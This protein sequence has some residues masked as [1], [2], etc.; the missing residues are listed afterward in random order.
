MKQWK[1]NNCDPG[2]VVVVPPGSFDLSLKKYVA[3]LTTGVPLRDGD[4]QTSND[5]SD[6]DRDILTVPQGG[7]MRYRFVVRNL[8]PVT[9]TGT[10]TV[11]DTLPNDTSIISVAGSGWSCTTSETRKFIC[12]R[13]EDLALGAYFPDIVVDAQA[14]ST[15]LAGEYSNTATVKNPGDTNPNNNTDPANIEIVAGNQCGAISGAPVGAVAPGTNTTYTCAASG[16]TGSVAN[17]EYRVDCGT[18]T[19]SWSSSNTGTCAAPNSYSSSDTVTCGVRD[20]NNPTTV[21]SGSFVGSCSATVTT[22][23]G[24]GG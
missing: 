7:S 12:T 17:L 3:D 16:Y 22:T 24:G 4:H 8:G 5:G 10:T 6:V 23:S 19:G 18:T 14:S 15:I 9:A 20:R 21:F 1:V 11:E 13:T 2:E